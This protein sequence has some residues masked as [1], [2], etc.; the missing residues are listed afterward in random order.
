MRELPA[1]D[2]HFRPGTDGRTDG[3]NENLILFQCG[4]CRFANLDLFGGSEEQ[5]SGFLHGSKFN[6]KDGNLFQDSRLYQIRFLAFHPLP[7]PFIRFYIRFS[8]S[9]IPGLGG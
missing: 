9:F 5:G 7:N 6:I 3:F 2:Q 1:V 8:Y 4:K